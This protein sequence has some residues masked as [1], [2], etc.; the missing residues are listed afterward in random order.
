M[1]K[2]V[3]RKNKRRSQLGSVNSDNS[4][5]NSNQKMRTSILSKKKKPSYSLGIQ[6]FHK[7]SS[8]QLDDDSNADSVSTIEKPKTRQSKLEKIKELQKSNKSLRAKQ[9]ELKAEVKL[10]TKQCRDLQRS[11]RLQLSTLEL[12]LNE[13]K[14]EL[15]RAKERS[16]LQHNPD[17]DHL[18]GRLL[19]IQ[20]LKQATQKQESR[21]NRLKGDLERR[22][23]QARMKDLRIRELEKEIRDLSLQ[24]TKTLNDNEGTQDKVANLEKQLNDAFEKCKEVEEGR[25][26]LEIERRQLLG[27][28]RGARTMITREQSLRT[29]EITHKEGEKDSLQEILSHNVETISSLELELDRAKEDLAEEKERNKKNV[30][31]IQE[32]LKMVLMT[33]YEKNIKEKEAQTL[34]LTKQIEKSKEIIESLRLDNEGMAERINWLMEDG[35]RLRKELDES[36]KVKAKE[37][38]QIKKEMEEKAEI[39]LNSAVTDSLRK[40]NKTVEAELKN[41]F[42]KKLQQKE[43][44]YLLIQRA[45]EENEEQNENLK[46]D[47]LIMTET[48]SKLVEDCDR[49]KKEIMDK[50]NEKVKEVAQLK[51][52]MGES[53]VAAHA[54]TAKLKTEI[55]LKYTKIN[56]GLQHELKKVMDEKKR[57]ETKFQEL[58]IGGTREIDR[59]KVEMQE[60][61]ITWQA[62]MVELKT[63]YDEKYNSAS[64]RLSE[65]IIKLNNKVEDLNKELEDRECSRAKQIADIN[66]QLEEKVSIVDSAMDEVAVEKEKNKNAMKA[67]KSKEEENVQMQEAIEQNLK[68]NEILRKDNKRISTRISVFEEENKQLKKSMEERELAQR[69][70]IMKLRKEMEEKATAAQAAAV[71]DAFAKIDKKLEEQE[72]HKKVVIKSQAQLEVEIENKYLKINEGLKEKIDILTVE[73]NRLKKELENKEITKGK[74]IADIN[75]QLEEKISVLNATENE[76]LMIREKNKEYKN[77]L[78]EK[79][80]ENLQMR[81]EIEQT[82]KKNDVLRKDNQ[83]LNDRVSSMQEE[84]NQI[85]KELEDRECSR[86]KQIADINEQLEEKVSIVDSAMDEVAVEKEKNKNAMKALKSKEEENVQMQEAIEQNLKENE[87]LRKDNKRISTRISVFEEENKQLKK[88]MEER[89]LAQRNEI[90]KLRKEME[91][92]AATVADDVEVTTVMNEVENKGTQ[93]DLIDIDS[94]SQSEALQ[95]ELDQLHAFTKT[96]LQ[97]V[98]QL[99]K[100][101]AL[102]RERILALEK[103]ISE[104]ESNF[105]DQSSIGSTT[106]NHYLK[107][108]MQDD[109][110]STASFDND[111]VS[112]SSKSR[113]LVGGLFRK[114]GQIV[115]NNEIVSIPQG[116]IIHKEEKIKVLQVAKI[117]HE[118]T[119]GS[120]VQEVMKLRKAQKDASLQFESLQHEREAFKMKIAVLEKEFSLLEVNAMAETQSEI[121]NKFKNVSRLGSSS[122]FV[123]ETAAQ[124]ELRVKDQKISYLE[125]LINED[126]QLISSMRSE[127][128]SHNSVS[129]KVAKLHEE[130]LEKVRR[131]NISL[132]QKVK[133]LEKENKELESQGTTIIDNDNE[134]KISSEIVEADFNSL[135]KQNKDYLIKMN[136]T[137]KDHERKIEALKRCNEMIEKN[138]AQLRREYVNLRSTMRSEIKKNKVD[139]EKLKQERDKKA[140]RITELEK[141]LERFHTILEDKKEHHNSTKNSEKKGFGRLLK[142]VENKES[143]TMLNLRLENLQASKE[144]EINELGIEASRLKEEKNQLEKDIHK[145]LAQIDESKLDINA[146]AAEL[147][148]MKEQLNCLEEERMLMEEDFQAKL[149]ARDDT[150][151]QLEGTVLKLRESNLNQHE[152]IMKKKRRKKKEKKQK[153]ISKKL[154]K[155]VSSKN[156]D[157][158]AVA[159]IL[160][161]MIVDENDDHV[162][163]NLYSDSDNGSHFETETESEYETESDFDSDRQNL[164]TMKSQRDT[165]GYAKLLPGS[166]FDD[167]DELESDFLLTSDTNDVKH[168]RSKPKIKKLLSDSGSEQRDTDEDNIF[169]GLPI[170]PHN[171]SSRKLN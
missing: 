120:L 32:K 90:M 51:K 92:K 87:I 115:D 65:Q 111:E 82:R 146:K 7:T 75:E 53:A 171:V 38:E 9:S 10:L 19:A 26:L 17:D 166:K 96:V 12:Q 150:V 70:E 99:E 50:E 45:K 30:V 119:I 165:T 80:E 93:T 89:E 132:F 8:S 101:K 46:Q 33:E 62:K 141:E 48:I 154:M 15:Q 133:Q 117:R 28:L 35:D 20:A 94:A 103:Q 157:V 13:T 16:K 139:I 1:D 25:D 11:S 161:K 91:E 164:P 138:S 106:I 39:A 29:L 88:S 123:A 63:E 112:I 169:E 167:I 108:E 34:K 31:R 163:G 58:E 130:Q 135:S 84:N 155:Q 97:K 41:D 52:E 100:D 159:S 137:V 122:G 102:S 37:I 21:I 68:E 81:D 27:K 113:S 95:K 83:G 152:V 156:I 148:F 72:N 76:I 170:Q 4:S 107:N 126:K 69:N 79:V 64:T 127:I 114:N 104:M 98:Q 142:P 158:D 110:Y 109:E 151:H 125:K 86:A 23:D 5:K 78:N 85:K 54:T 57:V 47:N 105:D 55:E 40:S 44:E 73:S 3:K 42:E 128:G 144:R 66:E 74:Q 67:L 43:E 61:E 36:A 145:Y 22:R 14:A 129:Q 118:K 60:N 59:M 131:E 121:A 6:P 116:E 136:K 56:E 49:L 149:T 71:A 24:V 143:I 134:D 160:E 168:V 140:A 162:H 2:I 77:A 124:L 147:E 153:A 18:D